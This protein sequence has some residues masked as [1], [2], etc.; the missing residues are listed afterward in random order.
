MK[1]PTHRT[2]R[3]PV[4]AAGRVL[5]VASLAA[6]G[7][8]G[9]DDDDDPA[10]QGTVT[11]TAEPG[12]P[13]APVDPDVDDADDAGDAD[14]GA[15][16]DDG[17][18]SGNAPAG[19]ELAF[20]ATVAPDFGSGRTD[21]LVIGEATATVDGSFPATISDIGVATDGESVYEIARFGTNT[22]TKYAPDDTSAAI[23]Q[24]SVEG[25]EEESNPYDI[26]FDGAGRGFVP[27]YGSPTLWIVDPSVDASDEAGF[28]TGELDLSAY[29][30]D[31]PNASAALVVGD[32]LYVLMERLTGFVPDKSGY[33]AVFDL[34]TD[35]E[36][37]TGQGTDGL[38][39][40]ALET[41]NPTALQYDEAADTVYVLGRGNYFENPEVPGDPYTGGLET[42][43]VDTYE[44]ALL[45][46][47]GTADD[48]RGYFSDALV[49]S[50]T[51]GYLITYADF[52][53]NSLVAFDPSTGTLA[54]APIPGFE[55]V[56]ISHLAEAPD[57]RIWVGLGGPTPG[58]AIL[59][60]LDD[61]IDELRVATELVP[62]DTAFVAVPG[63][64]DAAD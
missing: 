15:D 55:D 34:A 13:L 8:C 30:V 16:P 27:R 9:S 22:I 35:A 53:V 54:D 11:G 5:L 6:L 43:D 58:Y 37:D 42:I 40:I 62:R 52:Q 14:S 50:P 60:P 29:D 48:N 39:G 32:E 64:G 36:I 63:E 19:S 56:E 47:D 33:V 17:A 1:T 25:D 3:R 44:S 51:K 21:R 31:E 57:G 18:P 2:G 20:A 59:D 38:P 28:K 41:V 61:S 23:W 45:I 4:A 46:D 10:E 7:A 49:M 26:V 12:S 24:F